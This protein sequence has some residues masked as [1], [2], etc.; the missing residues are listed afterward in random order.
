MA[1]SKKRAADLEGTD[2][3]KK[4][5]FEKKSGPKSRTE[6]PKGGNPFQKTGIHTFFSLVKL[7]FHLVLILNI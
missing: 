3:M 7:C 5:K 6:K 2:Q 1:E 4:P